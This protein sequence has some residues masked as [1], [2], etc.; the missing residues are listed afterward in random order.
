MFR[1]KRKKIDLTPKLTLAIVLL[2]MIGIDNEVTHDETTYLIS[3]MHGDSHIIKEANEYLQNAIKMDLSF[4]MFLDESIK[5][6]TENQK[7]CII[8]NLIDIML[9]DGVVRKNE[10]KLLDFILKKYQFDTK[11]YSMY[12]EM[13]TIK[14][15]HSIFNI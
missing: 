4:E 9:V 11:K 5:I 10:Q 14:N 13:I 12:K 8:I 7:E 1:E 2:Y 15:D 6:L 3:V